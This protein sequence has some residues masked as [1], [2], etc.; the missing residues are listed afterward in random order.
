[1]KSVTASRTCRS[2]PLGATS[3]IVASRSAVCSRVSPS[4]AR[5]AIAAWGGGDGA[6]GDRGGGAGQVG[7]RVGG[8][9]VPGGLPGG[10]SAV[11]AVPLRWWAGAVALPCLGA[12]VRPADR[13]SG[14]LE[15]PD[16]RVE[17]DDRAAQALAVDGFEVGVC[18]R[19]ERNGVACH[20][21]RY[22]EHMFEV[23]GILGADCRTSTAVVDI[24][25]HQTAFCTAV[26]HRRQQTRQGTWRPT[27][28]SGA[29]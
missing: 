5:A 10:D 27:P 1:M 4:V 16:E 19:S 28:R 21:I 9:D 13:Q 25:F 8:R 22:L 15:V 17:R 12:A 3:R 2:D 20:L 24:S 14:S 11:V 18:R 7:Q 29:R 23:P 26:D 6:V